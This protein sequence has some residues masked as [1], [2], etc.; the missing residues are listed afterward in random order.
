MGD[1]GKRITGPQIL[2]LSMAD[3]SENI[4]SRSY[5]VRVGV[6]MVGFMRERK[7]FGF[8]FICRDQ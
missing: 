1:T 3:H 5:F 8:R 6:S 4:L 2:L 7:Q